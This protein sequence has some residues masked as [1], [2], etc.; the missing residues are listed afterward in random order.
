MTFVNRA[1]GLEQVLK[2]RDLIE[3]SPDAI[4]LVNANG[5]IILV[6]AQTERVFG[7]TRQELLNQPVETL[8]ADRHG[9][10]HG[11]SHGVL[12]RPATALT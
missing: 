3:L 9:A 4:V 2:F 1:D 11:A 12:Q 5:R 6:N 7:Y 8:M 10:A